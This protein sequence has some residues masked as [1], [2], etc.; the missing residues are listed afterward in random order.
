M[1]DNVSKDGTRDLLEQYARSEPRLQVVWAPQN[2]C[3]VDAYISGYRAALAAGC[4]WI[5]EMDAGFSHRPEQIPAFLACISEGFDC[6]FGSR[7]CESGA[8]RQSWK[9]RLISQGGTW[10]SN[11]VL[12][13]HLS[14][15][16]SGFELFSGE[17]LALVLEKGI[18]SRA[19]FFQT[20]IRAYCH[21]LRIREVPIVYANPSPRL[22]SGAIVEA[23][24]QLRRLVLCGCAGNCCSRGASRKRRSWRSPDEFADGAGSDF[25]S[26]AERCSAT[27]GGSRLDRSWRFYLIGDE[28]SPRDFALPGC[29]FYSLGR[30][31]GSGLGFAEACP[32]RHYARK[33]IGYLLALREGAEVIIETDD[34]NMPLPDFAGDRRRTA[35]APRV[36]KAGWLNVYRYYSDLSIWP[37][38]LPLD[39][40]QQ[41][42]PALGEASE[43]DCPIQQGLAD[44]NPDVD[45]VYRLLL[46]LPVQFRRGIQVA[47][48]RRGAGARST[49][50][51]RPGSGMRSRC[52]TCRRIAP[53]G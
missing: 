26:G 5:L 41:P 24:R 39:A 33:N 20:E 1:L 27:P 7:F 53:F 12:G 47:L 43:V 51:T 38:G 21:G 16:T 32:V 19:H 34:D 3:I 18:H 48:E 14:D 15:M 17:A 8:Y 31:R 11:A 49:A 10:L 35:I 30:Q 9:R 2:R 36:E 6:A 4:D 25:D 52:C 40:V 13:T 42:A 37:R 28:R 45:A 29:E 46:P 23:L 44:D 50:R 22:G